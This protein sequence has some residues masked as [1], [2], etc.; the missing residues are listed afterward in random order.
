MGISASELSRVE[1]GLAPWVDVP[2]LS[3]VSAVVGLDLWIRTYPGGE[4][5]RDAAHPALLDAFRS[6]VA[7]SMNLRMEVPIGDPRDL[8]AWD[9]VATEASGDACGVELDTRLVDAQDQLRRV[10]MKRHDGNVDRVLIVLSDTRSNRTALRAA[11]GL[12]Q[13]EFS[14]DRD[15]ILSALAD[16]RIPPRDGVLLLPVKAPWGAAANGGQQLS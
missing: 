1:R 7:A 4:P 5:L 6:V 8:R 2:T 15:E 3:R 10:T 14:L 16:G 11:A 13:S 12:F 9:V